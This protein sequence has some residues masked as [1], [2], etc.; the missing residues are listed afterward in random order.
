MVRFDNIKALWAKRNKSA[1]AEKGLTASLDELMAQRRNVRY[2]QVRNRL[3]TSI[4]AGDVKSA[5]KGRGIEMEEIREYAFGDD[6]RDIDWRVTARKNVPY[7]KVYTEERDRE[8]Y[9]LLDLSS[10]MF[11]GTRKELKS[12]TASKIA[13]LLG[14]LAQ[15]NK[16]RFGAVIFDGKTALQFKPQQNMAQL[17][18]IFK[19]ISEIS[20]NGGAVKTEPKAMRKTL[21]K[22]IKGLK[23]RATVFVVSDF[24]TFGDEEKEAMA[25]LARKTKVFCIDV[26]DMLE[27]QAPTPG[28]Y[29]IENNGETLIFDTR[30]KSFDDE[31]VKFFANKRMK[32]QDFCKKFDC[33]WLEV[34][35]DVP[36]TRQMKII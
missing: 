11:F 9:V 3:D 36:I 2:L 13:A 20:R 5:F 35:T 8:I 32:M 22:L 14:W 12:V 27:K 34:R 17:L 23:S 26:Y 4:Q 29:M 1:E 16:D 33:H 15:E 25:V 19:K 28:E 18:A 31:Y 24:A 21:Q 6:V 30:S 10:S 7:T